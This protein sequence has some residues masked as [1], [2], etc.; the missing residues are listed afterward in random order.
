V[1]RSTNG[2]DDLVAEHFWKTDVWKEKYTG[3]LPQ[4][5]IVFL[6]AASVSKAFRGKLKESARGN[7]AS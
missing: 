6:R 3:P 5:A 1:F 7:L 4:P 2:R